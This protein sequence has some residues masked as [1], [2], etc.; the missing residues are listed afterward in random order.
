MN[1][2]S[3][4]STAQRVARSATVP[5]SAKMQTGKTTNSFAGG[6]KNS[7]PFVLFRG[8]APYDFSEHHSPLR[9]FPQSVRP[10]DYL[11]YSKLL[12]I[13]T[14][15]SVSSLNNISSMALKVSVSLCYCQY[16][17]SLISEYSI[18]LS[19]PFTSFV[20]FLAQ[21]YDEAVTLSGVCLDEISF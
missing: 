14:V 16:T 9:W 17:N 8:F 12:T 13:C 21:P 19:L 2:G 3:N 6:S 18:R 20:S 7:L 11:P 5:K 4:I 10:T 15:L 1:Q